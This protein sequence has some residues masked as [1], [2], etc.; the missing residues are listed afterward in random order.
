METI[1][2][3]MSCETILSVKDT[4]G[5]SDYIYVNMR[6]FQTQ[7]RSQTK[8]DGGASQLATVYLAQ[9]QLACNPSV[10]SNKIIHIIFFKQKCIVI[11]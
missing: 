7:G 10:L 3:R 5:A 1:G 9:N 2:E 8:C 4:S 11:Y 6:A